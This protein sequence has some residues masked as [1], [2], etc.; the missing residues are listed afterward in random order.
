MRASPPRR[1][2]ST[3]TTNLAMKVAEDYTD[4]LMEEMTDLQDQI[5]AQ[6][7][8][9]LDSQVDV[10]ME[11]LRCPPTTPGRQPL[12]RR[13]A[14]RGA[15]PLLLEAPE[16]L[17][18]DEPT[19]HLDAETV[20][21]LQ[22]HLIEYKGTILIVTHDRYFLDNVTGWI[23]E[24]DRGR[25]IPYEGNYSAWLE[26][27]AK[28]LAQEAREDKRPPAHAVAASWNGSAQ[29]PR[30]ARPSPRRAST[31]TTS[32][33]Q[34]PER[35]GARPGPDRHPARPRGWRNTSSS[36]EPLEGLRRPAADRRPVLQAAAGRHRRR[37]R[38]ER[39]RQD[40]AVPHDHRAGAARQ[41]HDHLS[42]R[43]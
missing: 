25:G 29:G 15:L 7:L 11:A 27:K 14:P 31:P 4:E 12:G 22:K 39:R 6:N 19:N 37:D 34:E 40:H 10:A 28:R 32:C 2:C 26:Q 21:W 8:W 24:L 20:A 36:R 43:R 38:P 23:L 30:P 1:R 35:Q 33:C 18:L 13:A 5:D 42:A 3:A 16:M 17:L 41:R 9:D